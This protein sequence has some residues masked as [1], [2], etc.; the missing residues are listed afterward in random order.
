MHT[1][2]NI[3][4]IYI[5]ILKVVKEMLTKIQADTL[6]LFKTSLTT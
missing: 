2:Q 4:T 3:E 5:N 6:Q 1:E